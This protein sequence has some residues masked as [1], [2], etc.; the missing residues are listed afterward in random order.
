M[1]CYL[2]HQIAVNADLSVFADRAEIVNEEAVKDFVVNR[3][4]E[5][6]NGEI[7]LYEGQ[8]YAAK[9]REALY[10][11]LVFK[12]ITGETTVSSLTALMKVAALELN[13]IRGNRH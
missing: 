1:D 2:A 9:T 5:F 6:S 4:A 12:V 8:D 3:S 7:G 13:E 11:G 10:K